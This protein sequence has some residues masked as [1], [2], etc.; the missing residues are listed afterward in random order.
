MKTIAV[1]FDGVIHAYGHGWHDGTCYDV[2][3]P[4][5]IEGLKEL[6]EDYCVFVLSTRDT[7]QIEAWF[8][9]H[10]PE[11]PVGPVEDEEKFWNKRGIL[12]V[13]NRKLPA[14]VYID[15]RG[16]LFLDWKS[17]L[18]WKHDFAVYPKTKISG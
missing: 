11:I 16:F 9:K 18:K 7:S 4:G 3:M 17:T 14:M 6:M 10:A 15:D 13:T 12:G 2:P 8:G 5:A 1:D